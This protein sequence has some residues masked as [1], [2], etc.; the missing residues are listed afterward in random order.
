[1][2]PTPAE[3]V[4]KRPNLKRNGSQ[5]EGACPNCGGDDRFHVNLEPPHLFGCR[6]CEDAGAILKATFGEA[7]A[8]KPAD[9]CVD[10][11]WRTADGLRHKAYRMDW[12]DDWSGHPCD[13][14]DKKN[15]PVCVTTKPHKHTW[16]E[17]HTGAP[18]R[19][20]GLLV[21]FWRPVEPASEI[22]VLVEGP[23]TA[24]AVREAGYIAAT[25]CGGTS[26]IKTVDYSPLNGLDLVVWPDA[27]RVGRKAGETVAQGAYDAGATTIRFVSRAHT[28]G[29]TDSDAADVSAEE[30]RRIIVQALAD[31]SMDAAG[32][33]GRKLAP[34]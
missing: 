12:P 22:V 21:G 11:E 10:A 1:M 9:Q 13:W 15:G 25:W 34:A 2:R 24:R 8:R 32:C 33:Y 20:V 26:G 16:E 27:S 29:E 5:L 18:G 28:R 6:Q 23:K 7:R 19:P 4:A 14:R 17:K 30:R 31:R 3:W